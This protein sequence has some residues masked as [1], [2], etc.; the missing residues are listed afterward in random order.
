MDPGIGVGRPVTDTNRMQHHD[1]VRLQQGSHLGEKLVIV[2]HADMLE[3]SNGDD[4]VEL[5]FQVPVV[6]QMELRIPGKITPMRPFVRDRELLLR[7]CDPDNVSLCHFRHVKPQTTPTGADIEHLL[8]W[9]YQQFRCE[10]SLLGELRFFQR[11]AG[12]LEIRAGILAVAIKK[13]AIEGAV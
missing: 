9:L 2:A 11:T 7:K 13:Q 1:T 3:H 12:V 6:L 5:L 8:A 4:T 10:V